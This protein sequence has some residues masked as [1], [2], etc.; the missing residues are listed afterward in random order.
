MIYKFEFRD[1]LSLSLSVFLLL[2]TCFPNVALQDKHCSQFLMQFYS[3]IRRLVLN[4]NLIII[5]GK[6]LHSFL[7]KRTHRYNL[8]THTVTNGDEDAPIAE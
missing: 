6:D 5:K 4:K 7:M 2:G 1:F 3:K 8:L